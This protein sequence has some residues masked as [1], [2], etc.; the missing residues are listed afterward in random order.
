MGSQSNVPPLSGHNPA[1]SLLSA[2]CSLL[3]SASNFFPRKT[4]RKRTSVPSLGPC[5]PRQEQF[6]A[7][8]AFQLSAPGTCLVT[9]YFS[10][11]W[12]VSSRIPIQLPLLTP[13]LPSRPPH[14]AFCAPPPFLRGRCKGLGHQLCLAEGR[15]ASFFL[16]VKCVPRY[17]TASVF[18]IVYSPVFSLLP[19]PST[20]ISLLSP[21]EGLHSL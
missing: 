17:T 9:C 14:P 4:L 8:L 13:F 5:R 1:P 20:L 19:H 16:S 18:F 12:P 3:P 15:P 2:S 11:L 7:P 10:P 21:N 6:H